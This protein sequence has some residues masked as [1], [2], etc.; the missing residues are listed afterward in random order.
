MALYLPGAT[1]FRREDK[2]WVL[3]DQ[4][5]QAEARLIGSYLFF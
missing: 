3:M 5:W 2:E 1:E 4:A